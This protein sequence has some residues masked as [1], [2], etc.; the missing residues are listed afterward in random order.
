MTDGNDLLM[1]GGTPS[2][3]FPTRGTRVEGT[4]LAPPST[5]PQTDLK[6]R[7]VKR[8]ANGDAMMQLVVKLQTSEQD[9]QRDN[10]DGER[11]LYIRGASLRKLRDVVLAAGA[12]G[13]EVGGW[14]SQTYIDDEPP[15]GNLLSGAKV[16]KFEYRRPPV[17]GDD[18]FTQATG[19]SA[20]NGAA[21]V[22]TG[23]GDNAVAKAVAGLS[24]DQL[25]AL[26][27][28]GFKA[29]A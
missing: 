3:K 12:K 19:V 5:R 11:M 16:F 21:T 8:F 17:A 15:S 7:E 22:G 6:T 13:L 18:S 20:S 27:A 10:D 1:A 4:I 23:Q 2:A 9:P 29:A 28:L 24:D 25:A 26:A 14:I